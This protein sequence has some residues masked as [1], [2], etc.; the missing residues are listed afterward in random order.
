M[1]QTDIGMQ[2]ATAFVSNGT[3]FKQCN[4]CSPGSACLL[5]LLQCSRQNHV[6]LSPLGKHSR[7]LPAEGDVLHIEP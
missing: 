3:Y 7:E 4:L 2:L 5:F 1:G 6:T